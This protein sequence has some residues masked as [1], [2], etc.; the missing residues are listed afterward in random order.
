[1]GCLICS[2]CC[3]ILSP[4]ICATVTNMMN[5]NCRCQ[6]MKVVQE[7]MPNCYC[8]SYTIFVVNSYSLTLL[9]SN[10]DAVKRSE[11]SKSITPRF[12]SRRSGWQATK[13]KSI[14]TEHGKAAT[15]VHRL[16]YVHR[17]SIPRFF[18]F[19]SLFI[20]ICPIFLS[21][22]IQGKG[23]RAMQRAWEGI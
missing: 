12:V 2:S 11:I 16:H 3:S 20:Q 9:Q 18:K 4:L 15:H 23:N 1:M 10:V 5:Y 6:L 7:V 8:L 22:N 13:W 14:K 21:F 19:C 17:I